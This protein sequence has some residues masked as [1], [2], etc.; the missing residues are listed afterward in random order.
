MVILVLLMVLVS[1]VVEE[2]VVLNHLA[3]REE[4]MGMEDHLI[5]MAL[6]VRV[7]IILLHLVVPQL[8]VVG[9]ELVV[10]VLPVIV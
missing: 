6:V 9:V 4:I 7:L 2:V 8:M 1:I 5:I 10:K 3:S